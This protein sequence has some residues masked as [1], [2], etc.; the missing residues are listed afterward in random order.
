MIT[1]FTENKSKLSRGA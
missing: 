1:E